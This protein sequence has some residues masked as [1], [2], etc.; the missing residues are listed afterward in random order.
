MNDERREPL[1]G[2]DQ[3]PADPRNRPSGQKENMQRGRPGP[4]SSATEKLGHAFDRTQI[5][6]H[7]AEERRGRNM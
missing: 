1:Q 6:K 3:E 4:I 5:D 2:K 7:E